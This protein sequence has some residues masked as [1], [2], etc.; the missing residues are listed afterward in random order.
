MS[1]LTLLQR[2]IRLIYLKYVYE[3]ERKA[4]MENLPDMLQQEQAMIEKE[5]YEQGHELH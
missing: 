4:L 3:V 5:F 2:I 1:K